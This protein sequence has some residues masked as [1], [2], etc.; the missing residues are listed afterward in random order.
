M[1]EKDVKKFVFSSTCA[2]Y[3]D[4][5]YVPIDEK[6]SQNPI[7]PYGTTK[8]MIEHILRDYDKAYGLKHI[9]LRYFNASGADN[10]AN[11]GESH[12]PETHLIPLVLQTAIGNRESIKIFGNDYATP[13]GTCIRDYIHVND[14]AQAHRLGLE[15]LFKGSNSDFYN[16]GVGKGYSVQEIIEVS[17]QVTGKIINKEMAERRAGDPPSLVASNDKARQELGWN[18]VFTDIK[19]IIETAWHWENNRRY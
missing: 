17:E 8:L 9:K 12:D 10:E 6:H 3:G 13:D 16:L 7:N 5:L 4:P 1:N 2:T 19:D 15:K 11:I 14:L 18:P